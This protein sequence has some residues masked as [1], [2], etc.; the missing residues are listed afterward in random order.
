M[1]LLK[2]IYIFRPCRALTG[3]AGIFVFHAS[4]S[5]LVLQ[6][7]ELRRERAQCSASPQR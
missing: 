3:A 7:G 6:I 2:R 5:S 4:S 1:S